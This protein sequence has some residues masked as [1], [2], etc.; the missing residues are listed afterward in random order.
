MWGRWLDSRFC[1]CQPVAAHRLS[2]FG[3]PSFQCL[4]FQAMPKR[5][6]EP[7]HA[8]SRE[9]RPESPL[10]VALLRLWCLGDISASCLQVLAHA[11]TKSGCDQADLVGLASLG[12]FG[13]NPNHV[14]KQLMSR[15]FTD[16]VAPEPAVVETKAWGKDKTGQRVFVDTKPPLLL[17]HEWMLSLDSSAIEEDVLGVNDIS[18]FWDSQPASNPRVAQSAKYFKQALQKTPGLVPFA[19]HGDAAPHSNVDSLLVI[20]LRAM[21]SRLSVVTGL[22]IALSKPPLIE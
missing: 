17:P 3:F 2:V 15:V 19:L 6:L 11:A 12:G 4:V 21:T 16:M 18:T 8:P 20:S 5:K 10:A 9:I 7:D 13:V 14:Q 1:D 22:A